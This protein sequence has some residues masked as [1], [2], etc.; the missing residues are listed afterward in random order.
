MF[1]RLLVLLVIVIG[2]LFSAILV[3]AQA[4]PRKPGAT[5]EVGSS[6]LCVYDTIGAAIA[7]A[8]PGDTIK[9]ENSVFTETLTVNKNLTIVG[10][11]MNTSNSRYGLDS[12]KIHLA[13][14]S[15]CCKVRAMAVCFIGL[16]G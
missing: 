5:L 2:F 8:S 6:P 11:Y 15:F 12:R 14:V 3:M 9:T 10:G 4:P 1:K 13:G 7:D 16:E